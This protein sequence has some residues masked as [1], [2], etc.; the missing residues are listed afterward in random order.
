[1][2]GRNRRTRFWETD[3]IDLIC[4][5]FN[6]RIGPPPRAGIRLSHPLLKL[7]ARFPDLKLLSLLLRCARMSPPDALTDAPSE[8]EF[9]SAACREISNPKLKATNRKS[10]VTSYAH[11][12]ASAFGA[13]HGRHV[14]GPLAQPGERHDADAV[15]RENAGNEAVAH[16][17]RRG[18]A[19]GDGQKLGMRDAPADGV[20]R[21][22]QQL[23][24]TGVAAQGHGVHEAARAVAAGG[25]VDA[26]GVAPGGELP[27]APRP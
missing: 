3:F 13:Q 25:K 18:L 2:F 6:S 9:P 16:V 15:F 19:L 7:R 10:R 17:A 4:A 14:V 5:E 24:L 27:H 12:P 23:R 1:M 21:E 26:H 11:S 8:R 22:R 20:G